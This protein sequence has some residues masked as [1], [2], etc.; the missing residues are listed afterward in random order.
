MNGGVV[1]A[2][3]RVMIADDHALVREGLAAVIA[4]E[5]DLTMAAS[6]SNGR[7]CIEHYDREKPD[8]VLLDLRM[9]DLDGLETLTELLRRHPDARVIMLSS[10]AGDEAIYRCITAGAAGYVLKTSPIG[11]LL[12]AIRTSVEAR[13]PPGNEVA[14]QLA[15]RAF[16]QD[17]SQ[18]EIEV[19]RCIARG[20]GNKEIG[21]ELGIAEGTV[22]NHVNNILGKLGAA[23]RTHAVA[24]AARRGMIDLG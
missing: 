21:V 16:Y 9:A 7:D 14:Q 1:T 8:V 4:N 3:L 12:A 5:P 13:V 22:K 23:D 15:N 17:L 20:A 6:V 10:H 19:L 18:R 11:E 2:K 24:I